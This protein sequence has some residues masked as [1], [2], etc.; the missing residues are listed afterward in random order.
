LLQA[1][2]KNHLQLADELKKMVLEAEENLKTP[3]PRS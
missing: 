3:E 2:Y 1:P